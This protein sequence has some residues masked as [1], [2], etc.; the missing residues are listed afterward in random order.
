MYVVINVI[1]CG[2]KP[3]GGEGVHPI[4]SLPSSQSLTPLHIRLLFIQWLLPQSNSVDWQRTK[5]KKK[6]SQNKATLS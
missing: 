1:L 4:S 3:C 5:S 2:Y 6:I